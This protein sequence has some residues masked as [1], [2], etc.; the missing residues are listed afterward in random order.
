MV[1]DQIFQ[2][3]LFIVASIFLVMVYV[4]RSKERSK[5]KYYFLLF[6]GSGFAFLG[7]ALVFVGVL[8]MRNWGFHGSPV[9]GAVI[10]LVGLF[11]TVVSSL[12][13]FKAQERR[14]REQSAY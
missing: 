12:I 11:V 13:S 6:S 3:V 5:A 2:A 14:K 8:G 1:R 4:A 9:P 10:S 7:V